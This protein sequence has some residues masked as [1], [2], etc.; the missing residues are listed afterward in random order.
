[1]SYRQLTSQL[2]ML[3]PLTWCAHAYASAYGVSD[4][5]TQSLGGTAV[6]L[7]GVDQG[8]AYNPALMA[9][10]NGDEDTTRDGRFS[11]LVLV[12]GLSDGAKTAASAI[13]DDL[14]GELSAAI[15]DLNNNTN[16]L[17]AR[18]AIA[19]AQELRDAMTE[20]EQQNIYADV[21]TAFSL[22]EPGD[23]EGGAFFINSRL[24]AVGDSQIEQSDL[25]LLD[26]YLEALTYIETFGSAGEP[27]PELLDA[28]GGFIDPSEDI[29]SSAE[30]AALLI[31]EV[32]LAAARE[33]DLWGQPIAL[34]ITPK[35]VIVHSFHERWGVEEGEFETEN[36][37]QEEMFL[38]LD[39]GMLWTYREHWRIGLAIKDVV[40]KR[41][42]SDLE[43]E[44][45]LRPKPRLG[46]AYSG[47]QFRVGL[48]VDLDKQQQLQS[49]LPAQNVSAG[50]EWQPFSM[51]ALRVGYRHDLE[52]A[53]GD[54]SSG[55]ILLKLG[56]FAV[57]LSASSGDYEL[58]AA[59]QLSYYH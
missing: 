22:T 15:N 4:A 1:M 57:E 30:G 29:A 27:H 52:D 32:G 31:S 54:S 34:G 58:G 56:R 25:D 47:D 8:Y 21:Y 45:T 40:E 41:W 10:H 11:Y 23:R 42:V 48:D 37:R 49:G 14:E 12:D 19:S 43:Q 39:V 13:T 6:A 55:G 50:V 59:L 2:L 35:A 44:F 26:D 38:N 46:L 20:L 5:R 16:V 24:L 3:A 18:E 9:T 7:G 28:D 33:Y 36:S 53:L 51:V 17:T